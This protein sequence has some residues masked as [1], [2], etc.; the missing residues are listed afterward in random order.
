ME[1]LKNQRTAVLSTVS[2]SGEPQAATITFIVDYEF[3]IYFITRKNSRK[4]ANIAHNARVSVVTGFD[5]ENPSTLQMQGVAEIMSG[6]RLETILK[7]TKNVL[8]RGYD[9]WPLLKIAGLDFVVIKVKINWARW[10][11]FDINLQS[12]KYKE[13]FKQIIP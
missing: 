5:P 3:N 8:T 2:E 12:S 7:I 9:W 13:I 10:L 4:Y 6:N 11:N 1:F